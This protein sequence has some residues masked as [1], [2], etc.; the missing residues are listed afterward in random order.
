MTLGRQVVLKGQE[1]QE[2]RDVVQSLKNV[3]VV[4]LWGPGKQGG[5]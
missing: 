1:G 4:V 2:Q 5:A 3:E